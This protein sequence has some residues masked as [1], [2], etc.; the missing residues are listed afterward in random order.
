MDAVLLAAI[1][2]AITSVLVVFTT[3]TLASKR[4]ESQKREVLNQKYLNPLRLSLEENYFRLREIVAR[5]KAGQGGSLACVKPDDVSKR[6]ADWFNGEG[7]YLISSCYLTA[8]LFYRLGK[9]RDDLAYLRLGRQDDTRLL[10]LI[11]QVN[12]CFLHD[13]GVFYAT[14]PSLGLD[15]HLPTPSRIMSYREFC[16]MLQDPNRRVWFDR[17]IELYVQAGMN[18]NLD[19]LEDA[20]RSIAA[21]SQ[22]L[23]AAVRG[24]DSLHARARTESL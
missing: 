1:V 21:L 18:V 15:V 11:L 16:Q 23:D 14:Q 22:F 6:G 13:L 20:T 2:S 4:H 12:H 5:V 24:G 9:V 10:S 17:L 19:R 8:V 3:Q 7:C